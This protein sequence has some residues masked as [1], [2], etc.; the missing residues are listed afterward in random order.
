[1]HAK[2]GSVGSRP[3]VHR[4]PTLMIGLALLG[5]CG[6]PGGSG[7]IQIALAGPVSTPAYAGMQRAADMAV[8][9]ANAAG[10][11]DGRRLELVV[12]DDSTRPERAIVIATEL[13]SDPRVV[14][15]VGHLNSA[16]TLAAAPI[17]NDPAH[18][19]VNVSPASSSTLVTSAGP[20]TFRVCPSDRQHGPALA[21]WA[22]N[23]LRERH[24]V[25]LYSNDDYGRGLLG[26]FSTA[27]RDLGGQVLAS[28]PYLP[29]L[30]DSA[31]N[32]NP[33]LQ[34]GIRSRMNVLVIAGQAADGARILREARADGYTGTVMGA[35]GLT[36]LRDVGSIAN[37][38]YVS[39]AWLPDQ[40]GEASQQFVQAYRDRYG[41][42]PDQFGAMTYDAV[43]LLVQAIREVGPDRAAIRG[44]LDQVG[45]DQPAFQGVSGTIAFDQHGDVANK[46]V[47]VG[48]IRDG[49][50]VSAQ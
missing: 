30:L 35:D 14:A 26:S 15:V 2:H 42:A 27:F 33:Y 25:V 9:E 29:S 40:Q 18:G 4:V 5:A 36:G 13:V 20:W 22:V 23:H 19:L 44:Y 49:Q 11:I 1:M 43:R 10:G 24:A 7:N 8:D 6:S 41:S 48:V 38:V 17:Y 21:A 34:R 39:S 47:V 16:A 46:N 31:G 32:P 50:L 3:A 12:R 28:D 37:G 45:R